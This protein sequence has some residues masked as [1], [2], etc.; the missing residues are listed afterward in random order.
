[1]EWNNDDYILNIAGRARFVADDNVLLY[2]EYESLN[3]INLVDQKYRTNYRG[4]GIE[5]RFWFE[6]NGE[7]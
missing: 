6:K 3:K 5:F 7:N 1:M 2:I 4:V